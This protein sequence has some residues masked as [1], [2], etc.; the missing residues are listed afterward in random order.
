MAGSLGLCSCFGALSTRVGDPA[1][2]RCGLPPPPFV[3]RLRG[4]GADL[5]T[6]PTRV[7]VLSASLLWFGVA[8]AA[9]AGHL[10]PVTRVWLRRLRPLPRSSFAVGDPTQLPSACSTGVGP[11]GSAV[12]AAFPSSPSFGVGERS[13]CTLRGGWFRLALASPTQGPRASLPALPGV[14]PHSFP[15]GAALAPPSPP[16]LLLGSCVRLVR[17]SSFPCGWACGLVSTPVFTAG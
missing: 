16:V 4:V 11:S 5:S 15:W 1:D 2:V 13:C 9:F 6:R 12:L 17:R 7:R 8:L 3:R 14:R 10:A